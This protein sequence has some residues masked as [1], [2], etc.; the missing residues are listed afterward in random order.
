MKKRLS[1]KSKLQPV[2]VIMTEEDSF[3]EIYKTPEKEYTPQ[4]FS[5][6]IAIEY[7]RSYSFKMSREDS[8]KR[9]NCRA[10]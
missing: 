7:Q 8:R 4:V 9:G 1:R 2:Q 10:N 6:I 3:Q 5:P